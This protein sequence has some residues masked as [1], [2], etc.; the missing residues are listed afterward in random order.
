MAEY[1]LSLG[2]QVIGT[3]IVISIIIPI[4]LAVFLPLVTVYLWLTRYYRMSN[5]RL[6]SH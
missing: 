4:M 5:P 3:L 1:A 2:L 6:G